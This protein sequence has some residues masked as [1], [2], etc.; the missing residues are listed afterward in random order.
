MPF[1]PLQISVEVP[2]LFR[3]CRRL[4]SRGKIHSNNYFQ[5]SS[6]TPPPSPCV[7]SDCFSKLQQKTTALIIHT[8]WYFFTI[9]LMT[10]VPLLLPIKQPLLTFLPAFNAE[11]FYFFKSPFDAPPPCKIIQNCPAAYAWQTLP[12]IN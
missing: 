3:K 4:P 11:N 6:P 10:S 7:F 5:A 1:F 2:L 8:R 9:F 12:S